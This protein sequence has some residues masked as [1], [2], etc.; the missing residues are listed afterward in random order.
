MK[1][2]KKYIKIDH[3]MTCTTEGKVAPEHTWTEKQT[4][5]WKLEQ[6]IYTALQQFKN[7]DLIR[8]YKLVDERNDE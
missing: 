1:S 8:K 4:A 2:I 3:M 7:V 5:E 6:Q